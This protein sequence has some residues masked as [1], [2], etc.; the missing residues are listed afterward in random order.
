MKLSDL[1]RYR[2]LAFVA[3]LGTILYL[4]ATSAGAGWLCVLVAIIG[5]AIAISALAPWWN[6]RGL[7][8]ARQA[9]FW[10]RSGI[11]SSVLYL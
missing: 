7:K 11:L 3:R 2:K 1:K 8:V 10:Q 9:Q 6:V 4:I 5:T